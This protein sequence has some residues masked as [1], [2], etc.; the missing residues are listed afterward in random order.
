MHQDNDCGIYEED[1]RRAVSRLKGGKTPGVCNIMPE[2]LKAG[3]EVAIE[4]LVKL[5]NVVWERG[6]VPRD[7]TSGIIVPIHKKGSKL[8]CTNYRGISLLTVIEKNF[9]KILSE[10]FEGM[11]S[12]WFGVHKGVRQGCTLSPWLF[13]VFI[14]NVVKEARRGGDTLN[15]HDRYPVVRR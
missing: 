3:G 13:N 4:W 14:D 10:G 7:W 6:V 1:M 9:A 15:G 2:M 8:E 11:E 12:Q 5:F